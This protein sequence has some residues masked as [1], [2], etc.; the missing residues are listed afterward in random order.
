MKY[1][2]KN[3]DAHDQPAPLCQFGPGGDYTAPWPPAAE[4]I[5][6]Q[7]HDEIVHAQA[8]ATEADALYQADEVD[9][10]MLIAA[11]TILAVLRGTAE[12]HGTAAMDRNRAER[13]ALNLA[14]DLAMTDAD[15]EIDD[16]LECSSALAVE[17]AAGDVQ[18]G[19]LGNPW[20]HTKETHHERTESYTEAVADSEAD[21]S[22]TFDEW[23]FP[24]DAGDRG[25]TGTDEGHR[26]RARRRPAKKRSADTGR[27][28]HG[29]LFTGLG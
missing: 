9:S 26:V 8:K 17:I 18:A 1:D 10:D 23:L 20:Q 29:P 28:A 15:A 13:A 2:K 11:R 25:R 21:S 14:M 24:D 6:P 19:P 12:A 4:P 5:G 16:V 7:A 27:E 3:H 22:R